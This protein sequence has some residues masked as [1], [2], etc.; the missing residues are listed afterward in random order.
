MPGRFEYRPTCNEDG[1]PLSRR[2]PAALSRVA[3][4]AIDV[5]QLLARLEEGEP[6]R[7][8]RIT[9]ICRWPPGSI[10]LDEESG[11]VDVDAGR[12]TVTSAGAVPVEGLGR[13]TRVATLDLLDGY[14]EVTAAVLDG[15]LEV[16]GDIPAIV[17][18]GQALEI[19]L[20]GA[21]RIPSLQ[22]L[23]RDFRDDPCSRPAPPSHPAGPIGRR[24]PFFIRT[25]RQ[26]DESTSARETRFAALAGSGRLAW[27]HLMFLTYSMSAT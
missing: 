18:I 13:L 20:D 4:F 2:R 21:A 17:A 19:L 27:R 14:L 25:R 9:Q 5:E 10:V 26:V 1:K 7:I 6:A 23:A 24:T 8:A 22:L 12:I 11:D 16:V 15:A 3:R